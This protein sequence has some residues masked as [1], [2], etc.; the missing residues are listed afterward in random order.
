MLPTVPVHATSSLCVVL[1]DVPST[2]VDIV[3]F[4]THSCHASTVTHIP[5]YAVLLVEFSAAAHLQDFTHIFPD[6]LFYFHGKQYN[7][8]EHANVT[9]TLV[10]DQHV[11]E[12]DVAAAM[13]VHVMDSSRITCV[14]ERVWSLATD[15]LTA[16]AVFKAGVMIVPS[17]KA[18]VTPYPYA[19]FIYM[20]LPHDISTRDIHELLSHI[21]VK[22]SECVV[23]ALDSMCDVLAVLM[24][25]ESSFNAAVAMATAPSAHGPVHITDTLLHVLYLAPLPASVTTVDHIQSQHWAEHVVDVTIQ[26]TDTGLRFAVLHL[27]DAAAR[28]RLRHIGAGLFVIFIADSPIH[29]RHN[30]AGG[31]GGGADDSTALSDSAGV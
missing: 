24:L 4:L 10:A 30:A 16:H 28:Q 6:R 5:Q 31:R 19:R 21:G 11:T 13:G 27:R 14:D 25:T 29:C 15:L 12:T 26:R 1:R 3:H 9:V 18:R 2:F 17:S 8:D 22:E 20:E 23:P 7:Y